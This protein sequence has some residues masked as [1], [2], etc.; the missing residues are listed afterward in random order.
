MKNSKM[1]EIIVCLISLAILTF[2][3]LNGIGSKV[4]AANTTSELD[5]LINS[6]QNSIANDVGDDDDDDDD[7]GN[8]VNENKNKNK[9]NSAKNNTANNTSNNANKNTN[10]GI[11]YAGLD[12]SVTFVIIAFGISAVF[13]YKKIRDYKNI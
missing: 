7:D 5:N 13:A 9:N 6:R 12:N 3:I 2:V 1:K 4:L 11:P 8:V 10:S